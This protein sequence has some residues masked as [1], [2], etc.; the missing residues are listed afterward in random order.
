MQDEWR[1]QQ[2]R[3]LAAVM[4]M[5]GLL[6]HAAGIY[7]GQVVD[8]GWCR[9]SL[10][11]ASAKLDQLDF[12]PQPLARWIDA[13]ETERLGSYFETL[14]E[15]WLTELLGYQLMAR[16][17]VVSEGKRQLGEFDFLFRQHRDATLVHW[18]V[19][20]KF[21]LW[22]EGQ[23]IGPNARDRLQRKIGRV[24]DRQLH[25]SEE[26]VA[27]RQL[28]TLC[29]AVP[30][31]PRAFFK[32]RLFYPVYDTERNSALLDGLS[33]GHERGWWCRRGELKQWLLSSNCKN[34]WVVLPRL[35][36]LAHYHCSGECEVMDSIEMA[37][38]VTSHFSKKQHALMVAELAQRDDGWHELTRGVIVN[39]EWPQQ[40]TAGA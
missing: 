22:F 27:R 12:D 1:H 17:L 35:K 3:D 29:G 24:F 14:L 37:A 7:G 5:P 10:Q 38:Y 33:P 19:T 40:L 16:N 20:V 9:G 15:Y 23:F 6:D 25:L 21:Y 30:V 28:T 31:V 8:D 34:R 32:G 26:A 39:D 13:H 36:W 2:V 4:T 11:V 18:E